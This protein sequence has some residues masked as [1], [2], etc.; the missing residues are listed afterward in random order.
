MIIETLTVGSFQVN[1][2][3]VVSDNNDAVL[4]DAGGDYEATSKAANK[5]NAKIKYV[6][7]THAHL[8]HIAGDYDIQNKLGAKVLLNKDDEFLFDSFQDH[9]KMF[10]MPY[11]KTPKV[12]EYV[13]DGQEIKL[14]SL[15]FK[16]ISTPGHSP[17]SVCYL[18]DNVLFSGD[19]LFADTVG[20]TDLPGGSY[21]ELGDS[22]K[23]KLFN[24]DE[25]IIVYPGHGD[26]TTIEHEKYFNPFFGL[27]K[28]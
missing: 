28:T 3:L 24:L 6:L 4:I 10:G 9:L 19:T 7:N 8:D 15:S 11:Y 26:S 12:D 5:Y 17:G 16:V 22:I 1:N 13:T 27:N 14:G 25:S 23:N 20:R 2:Y 21:D 18:T